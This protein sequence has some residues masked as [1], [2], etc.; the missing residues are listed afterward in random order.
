MTKTTNAAALERTISS[1]PVLSSDEHA[2]TIKLA[3]DLAAELDGQLAASGAGQTRTIATY[4]GVLANLRRV[5]RDERE[6]R[7]REAAR[8]KP[9]G[10]LAGIQA[11]A[12]AASG[13]SA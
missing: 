9:A 13:G 6:R 5:V 10:R 7:R 4:A 1:D 11:H 8:P 12:A 3:R 2:A